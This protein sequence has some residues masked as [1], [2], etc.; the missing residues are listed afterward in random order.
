M[1]GFGYNTNDRTDE[2]PFRHDRVQRYMVQLMD[3]VNNISYRLHTTWTWTTAK[4]DALEHD[5]GDMLKYWDGLNGLAHEYGAEAT[6]PTPIVSWKKK[7][8]VGCLN[9]IRRCI[10]TLGRI[11]D[12]TAALGEKAHQL[13][14]HCMEMSKGPN[15][16]INALQQAQRLEYFHLRE[17]H[18]TRQEEEAA[19]QGHPLGA[20]RNNEGLTAKVD[21][22]GI[23]TFDQAL[24]DLPDEVIARINHLV[25]EVVRKAAEE[26]DAP[27]VA[28]ADSATLCR[29][30]PIQRR[31]PAG[32]C[33]RVNVIRHT[34]HGWHKNCIPFLVNVIVM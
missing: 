15:K 11:R 24:P 21:L 33:A 7:E 26:D 9:T 16:I 27:G 32:R 2:I 6:D 3:L 4:C 13:P 31:T 5:L 23:R 18:R 29:L 12:N 8:K 20:G 14:K 34:T 1:Y 22:R 17:L 10:E 30:L 28:H 25:R 19:A